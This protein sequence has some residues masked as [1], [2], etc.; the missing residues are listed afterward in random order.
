MP[1]RDFR[2]EKQVACRKKE[3]HR[4]LAAPSPSPHPFWV[5]GLTG[6]KTY[7]LTRLTGDVVALV[8]DCV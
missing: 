4:L 6:A 3:K 5:S 2:F 7:D 1:M 8:P